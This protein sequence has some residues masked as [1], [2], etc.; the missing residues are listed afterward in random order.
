MTASRVAVRDWSARNWTARSR[1]RFA[2][3]KTP[4]SAARALDGPHASLKYFFE[5]DH[6]LRARQLRLVPRRHAAVIDGEPMHFIRRELARYGPH[7]F[8]SVVAARVGG[9]IFELLFQ[10]G[11]RLSEKNRRPLGTA[12]PRPMTRIAGSNRAHRI[13]LLSQMADLE[14][15][16]GFSDHQIG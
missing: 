12:A 1:W 6:C 15:D 3:H 2:G 4:P 14:W 11:R 16:I 13:A 5:V 8:E 10:V 9:E 7:P